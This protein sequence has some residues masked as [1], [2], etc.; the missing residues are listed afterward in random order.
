MNLGASLFKSK[1]RLEAENTTLRQQLIV[2]QRRCAV[3]SRFTN[4]EC[5][6]LQTRVGLPPG[7][8]WRRAESSTA[9]YQWSN[10][11]V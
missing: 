10:A 4:S 3:G 1:N 8:L 11:R 2:L 5:A 9:N 6:S 7:W